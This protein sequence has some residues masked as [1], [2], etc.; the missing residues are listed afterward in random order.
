ML[1]MP[2]HT[3]DVHELEAY[4]GMSIAYLIHPILNVNLPE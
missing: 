4:K 3:D 1:R 2:G